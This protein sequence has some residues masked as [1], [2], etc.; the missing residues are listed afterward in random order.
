MPPGVADVAIC[1]WRACLHLLVKQDRIRTP[2]S[3]PLPLQIN[4]LS[5]LIRASA[6]VLATA[7]LAG[8]SANKTDAPP[9]T[10]VPA[11]AAQSPPVTGAPA[12]VVR[13]LPGLAQAAVFDSATTSLAVLSPLFEGQSMVTV[14]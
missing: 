1:G 10:I 13:P 12:G 4:A 9:P 3:Y 8:C 5:Q 14:V 6:V 2:E 11:Q 7:V